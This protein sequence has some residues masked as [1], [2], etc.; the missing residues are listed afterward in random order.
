MS[1][2]AASGGHAPWR[3]ANLTDAVVRYQV[4]D[5]D[6][7]IEFYTGQLDFRLEQRAGP[8]AIVTR[9]ALNL[10]LSGPASSGSRPTGGEQQTPGGWNRIVLY[11]DDLD[12]Q[13][14]R[15]HAASVA[16]LSDVTVGPGGKQVQ[17]ADPDGNSIELHQAPT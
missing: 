3:P 14:D 1:Q 17:I 11:V 2:H 10:L 6:R 9:G 4:T 13:V 7:A 16:F 12:T 8:V 15:L 5:L